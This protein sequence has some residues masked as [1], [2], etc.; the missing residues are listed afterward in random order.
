[1]K[2]IHEFDN[3]LRNAIEEKKVPDEKLFNDLKIL[4]IKKNSSKF[5][6]ILDIINLIN[7]NG[8]KNIK[9]LDYGCGGGVTIALLYLA[10]YKNIYGVDLHDLDPTK[11]EKQKKISNI[12][13]LKKK[14]FKNIINSKT[15]FLDRS[16]NIIISNQVVEHVYDLNKYILELKRILTEDGTAILIFPH[17]LKPFETHTKTFI[18]HY[19][20]KFI[21]GYF[22]DLLTNE[23]KEYYFNLLNL[24]YPNYYYRILK[25]YFSVIDNIS[26]D[27]K[28]NLQNIK[29][30]NS[31]SEKLF[32]I[33]NICI[34]FMPIPKLYKNKIKMIFL[35][36]ILICKN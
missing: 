8:D 1:M 10:G 9:I 34:N 30:K 6:H 22:Y 23:K 36:M 19:F 33:I 13:F 27:L 12:L 25:N 18:I 3:L 2:T 14:I 31:K 32:K 24:K 21:Q 15:E 35:D 29:N 11:K 17:R 26:L 16:F 20:P 7:K 4:S 28:F 5:S